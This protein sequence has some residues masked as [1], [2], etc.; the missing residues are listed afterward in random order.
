M[1]KEEILKRIQVLAKKIQTE[2]LPNGVSAVDMKIVQSKSPN[3]LAEHIKTE[4][5][6]K[7]FLTL[8]HAL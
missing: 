4:Q 5:Q 7:T 6:A 1:M 2:G 3:S 8:L